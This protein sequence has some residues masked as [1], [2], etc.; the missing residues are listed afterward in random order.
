MFRLYESSR[1]YN[2]YFSISLSSGR[3]HV[4]HLK[5]EGGVAG[6]GGGING[7]DLAQGRQYVQKIRN[8]LK[9]KQ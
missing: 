5:I 1:K 9:K 7:L 3:F 2:L 4:C 6:R 8:F